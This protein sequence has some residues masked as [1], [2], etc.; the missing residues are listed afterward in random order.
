[1]DLEKNKHLGSKAKD[2][3]TFLE[4]AREI[5]G[6]KYSY[7]NFVYKNC[8]TKGLIHCNK[9]G[10]DFWMLPTNHICKRQGC[11]TCYGTHKLN[12]EEWVEEC[13]KKYNYDYSET[14]YINASTKVKIICHEKDEFGN[15][16]GA[17]W[18]NP[19]KHLHGGQGCPKCSKRAHVDFNEFVKRS[20]CKHGNKYTYHKDEYTNITENTKI[21]CPIHG[22]FYQIAQVHSSGCGCPKCGEEKRGKSK[23]IPFKEFERR[24]RE[25]Y[26]DKYIYHEDKYK[27]YSSKTIVTCPIH[28]DFEVI[29]DRHV[30]RK[31]ACK[32]CKKKELSEKFLL[33]FNEFVKRS[34]DVHGDKYD[35]SKS[36]YKGNMEQ[37]EIICP[38]HGSFWQKPI[39]H[40]LGQGCPKCNQS[41]LERN[42][43]LALSN[44][45]VEYKYQATKKDLNFL[46]MMSLD[47]YLPKYKIAIECQGIQHFEDNGMLKCENVIKRDRLKFKLCEENN[48]KLIYYTDLSE[49]IKNNDFYE[50]KEYFTNKNN[51]LKY[52]LSYETTN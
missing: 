28:G 38:I 32:E 5:H 40:W 41:H 46:G 27:N 17:F 21:T 10:T 37:I 3:N 2:F 16:H 42:I 39:K 1:M 33:P 36:V 48:I 25:V 51:F 47:F 7:D 29:P 43:E 34:R 44:I 11:P 52:I 24:A 6:D 9:C 23:V 4:E 31:T 49:Q 13:K 26:G 22:S 30:N 8:K 19:R 12:T 18:K 50:D 35:Y 45:N 15:E 20:K 14:E